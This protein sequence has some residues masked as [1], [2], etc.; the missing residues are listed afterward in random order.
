MLFGVEFLSD[1]FIFNLFLDASTSSFVPCFLHLSLTSVDV[2][3]PN[4][5]ELHSKDLCLD[6]SF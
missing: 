5:L 1:K 4:F 6:F 2:I 3:F